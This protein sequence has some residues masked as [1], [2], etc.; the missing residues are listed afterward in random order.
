MG[1]CCVLPVCPTWAEGQARAEKQA[2]P[3]SQAQEGVTGRGSRAAPSSRGRDMEPTLSACADRELVL[4]AKGLMV[5][6]C[7]STC[8][9]G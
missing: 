6:G 4:G 1:V 5:G 9:W 7:M 3:L 8:E 2:A